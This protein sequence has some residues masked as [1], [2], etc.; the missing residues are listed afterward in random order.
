MRVNAT[1]PNGDTYTDRVLDACCGTG[2]FLIDAL[3]DMW[4]KVNGN[5]ALS[6]SDKEELR[7]IIANDRIVGVDVGR[8][9]NLA[10]IA[11]LNMYLHGDGGSQIFHADALDK[12][13]ED[14]AT[15]SPEVRAER[16]QLRTLFDSD[17]G[18]F[19]V[20]LTNPP[21]AKPYERK[22]TAD[23][24]ILNNYTMALERPDTK[25]FRSS[26]LF[27]E[28]YHDLLRPG[29]RLVSVIDDGI[30]SGRD[31]R[32]FR[33]VLRQKYLI[34][35][36]ISLPGDAFQ[37]SR[38]RVK[39]SF[40]VL[41]KRE[42]PGE[43]QP[44]VFMYGCR[45]VGND[46][47]SR[48]RTLPNDRIIQE[49]ARAEI[50]EV[51]EEFTRFQAGEGDVRY[52]VPPDRVTERL[53]V[54]HCLMTTGHMSATWEE[55]G[56][57]VLPLEE[58]VTPKDFPAEDVIDAQNS[59]EPVT[60]LIVRYDGRATAGEEIEPSNTQHSRL[61]RVRTDD[62][63]ISNIAASYGSIAVVPPELDGHVIG[64]EYTVL[65][66][67]AGF[68][69]AVVWSVL[70]SDEVRADMLLVATGA[71]RT[72]IRWD[73]IKDVLVPYPEA[74]AVQRLA[75]QLNEADAA[76]RRAAAAREQAANELQDALLLNQDYSRYILD[77]FKPPR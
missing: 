22:K 3:A 13:V 60:Y 7:D 27:F 21:F 15:D 14:E 11:R 33:D 2:G 44:A 24:R 20:V 69:P 16:A 18:V 75:A 36:V 48:E 35:A 19:D 31:Y 23:Q 66:A 56:V 61:Y 8:D 77:A 53:D 42:H 10:R 62:I 46:D 34:R 50:R 55:H 68:D 41:E 71:N 45:Y 40:L 4:R 49:N 67:Q 25:K 26:L 47:P 74:D 30:L 39:T 58:I 37:R 52:V 65:Q 28:R 9:P 5:Q 38:A 29:G 6:D 70:R 72:R 76:E 63:V 73:G 64:S 32:W 51:I 12:E 43:D 57:R 17:D 1:L 59:D 54:K